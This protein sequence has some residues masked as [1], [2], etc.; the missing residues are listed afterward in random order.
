MRLSHIIEYILLRCIEFTASI[1]PRP[2]CLAIGAGFGMILYHAG[3]YRRIVRKNMEHVALWPQAEME[4]ITKR[5][6]ANIGRYAAEFLR[7]SKKLPPYRFDRIDILESQ[8]KIGKGIIGIMAHIGN[9]EIFAPIFAPRI[10]QLTVVT[11]PMHNK[12]VENWLAGKRG[13]AGLNFV[14]QDQAVRKILSTLKKNG[15]VALLIDQYAGS[16]GTPAL[17]LGKEA[18]TVRSVAGLVRRID[19]S[20]LAAYAILE[21]DLT[22]TIHFENPPLP[23]VS[24]D[25][26][27]AFI[28]ACQTLHNKMISEWIKKYPDHYFG[29]FHRRFKGTVDY[30]S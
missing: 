29:W 19:C 9:W 27:N 8:I 6:Y 18:N 20:V 11:M 4:A 26:E 13:G 10:S 30:R 7:A 23:L 1:I 25:D 2:F 22:Y 3:I 15:I 28:S 12:L 21:K 16:E 14:Y 17:F 24:K 5:L